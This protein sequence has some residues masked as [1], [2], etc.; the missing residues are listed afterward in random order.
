[1]EFVYF[2]GGSYCWSDYY[3]RENDCFYEDRYHCGSIDL[4]EELYDGRSETAKD[5]M[6]RILIVRGVYRILFKY[7]DALEVDVKL[8]GVLEDMQKGASYISVKDDENNRLFAE[9][10]YRYYVFT[11]DDMVIYDNYSQHYILPGQF[12]DKII[13]DIAHKLIENCDIVVVWRYDYKDKKWEKC[14]LDDLGRG[15]KEYTMGN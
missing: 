11:D 9:K 6:I 4:S 7:A 10:S 13:S 8:E 1:M 12:A 2:D 15:A 14:M 3:D 5:E